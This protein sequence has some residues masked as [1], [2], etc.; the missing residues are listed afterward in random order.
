M[1]TMLCHMWVY[2]YI[3]ETKL[4]TWIIPSMMKDRSFCFH[5][6]QS[7][8]KDYKNVYSDSVT[9][10]YNFTIIAFN[11]WKGHGRLIQQ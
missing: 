9:C 7:V 5:N 1:S 6:L 4:L 2:L 3:F 8:Y 10:I 11:K